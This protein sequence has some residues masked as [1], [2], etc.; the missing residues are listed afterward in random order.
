VHLY[1][2]NIALL[3]RHGPT[4]WSQMDGIGHVMPDQRQSVLVKEYPG[5]GLLLSLVSAVSVDPIR[6]TTDKW[7]ARGPNG[8]LL[9]I[10]HN[11]NIE[12]LTEF[13]V[14]E[15]ESLFL[16]PALNNRVLGKLHM[17]SAK[18]DAVHFAAPDIQ[19]TTE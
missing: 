12:E 13:K 16:D 11:T 15:A 8:P 10:T 1:R 3:M 2:K 14:Y 18:P 9:L 17:D 4:D 5:P 6:D 19:W 7:Q